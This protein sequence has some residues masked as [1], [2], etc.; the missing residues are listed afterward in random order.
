MAC[1]RVQDNTEFHMWKGIEE[2]E[3]LSDEKHPEMTVK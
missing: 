1:S 2:Y 3:K